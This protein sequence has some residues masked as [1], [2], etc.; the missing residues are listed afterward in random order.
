MAL[1]RWSLDQ[2]VAWVGTTALII[3]FVPMGLYVTWDVTLAAERSLAERG[4]GLAKT[5]AGQIV[6]HT[7]MEDALAVHSALHRAAVLDPQIRYICVENR[8]GDVV[9]H[10]FEGGYPVALPDLW[11]KSVRQ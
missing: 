9:A 10:T 4:L 8:S 3:L 6:E 1:S 5:L 2:L 7:L 11:E